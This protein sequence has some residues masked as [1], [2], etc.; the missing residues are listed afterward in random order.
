MVC[1]LSD[2]RNDVN[3]FKTQVDERTAGEWFHCTH[4]RFLKTSL[5][6][7]VRRPKTPLLKLPNK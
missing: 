1:Y 3:M 7:D 5:A 4:L 2:H 6:I